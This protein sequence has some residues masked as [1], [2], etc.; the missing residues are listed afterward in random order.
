MRYI[1]RYADQTGRE[2]WY[3]RRGG[4]LY[5]LPGDP[6]EYP[7]AYAKAEADFCAGI[8]PPVRRSREEEE[9]Q[10]RT[11]TAAIKRFDDTI[12]RIGER[13][14]KRAVEK[15]REWSIT[16]EW[17]VAELIRLDF[18]CAVTGLPFSPDAHGERRNPFSPSLDRIDSD[19]G[20]TPDNVRIVLLSV[21]C[22]ISDWGLEHFRLIAKAFLAA[23]S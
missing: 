15:R 13:A 10:R 23:P 21:N 8:T 19:G 14:R 12:D 2:R 1:K 20:Y 17:V 7:E 6:I 11:R 18:K 3:Y 4:L 16:R 9:A 5:T 22:A